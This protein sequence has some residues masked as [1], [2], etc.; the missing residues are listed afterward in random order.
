MAAH[1]AKFI[2]SLLV[3][4]AFEFIKKSPNRLYYGCAAVLSFVIGK[5]LI[6][7]ILVKKQSLWHDAGDYWFYVLGVAAAVIIVF[8]YRKRKKIMAYYKKVNTRSIKR[9]K[10][11]RARQRKRSRR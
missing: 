1:L 2:G 8:G 11:A 6:Y 9:I 7:D 3:P 4:A 10:N 5:E